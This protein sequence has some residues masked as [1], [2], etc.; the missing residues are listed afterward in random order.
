MSHESSPL[1]NNQEQSVES[2]SRNWK[3]MLLGVSLLVNMILFGL[4]LAGNVANPAGLR[5]NTVKFYSPAKLV[6]D[7]SLLSS[8]NLAPTIKG[9][10]GSQSFGGDQPKAFANDDPTLAPTPLNLA[11][12]SKGAPGS[13][14]SPDLLTGDQPKDVPTDD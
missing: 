6:K 10:P 11:A 1:I 7:Y 4:L 8:P 2:K 14:S 12:N 3:S 13:Q 5:T 9:S